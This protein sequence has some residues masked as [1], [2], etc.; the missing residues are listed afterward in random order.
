VSGAGGP[1][2]RDRRALRDALIGNPRLPLLFAFGVLY[3]LVDHALALGQSNAWDL[4][5]YHLYM[6]WAWVEGRLE[7]DIAAAQIQ[8]FYNPVMH[9]PLLWSAELF[10]P[11]LHTGLLAL[12]QG[13]NLFLLYG[14][15]LQVLS[16]PYPRGARWGAL[17]VAVMGATGATVLSELGTG[18]GENLVSLPLL[19]GALVLLR[20]AKAARAAGDA[21]PFPFAAIVAAGLLVGAATG[22][23]L[24]MAPFAASL[25][26]C[27]ALLV[28]SRRARVRLVLGLACG[29]ALGFVLAAGPWMFELWSR[30]GNPLYPGFSD[31]FPTLDYPAVDLRE[32]YRPPRTLIEWVAYPLVWTDH[33]ARAS[34]VKFRDHRILFWYLALLLLPWW[35][36]RGVARAHDQRAGVFLS[37]WLASSYVVSLALFGYYRFLAPLEMLAPAATAWLVAWVWPSGGWRWYVLSG[38]FLVTAATQRTPDRGYVPF[39]QSYVRL[40]A[41]ALPEQAHVVLAGG[42]PTAF[43]ALALGPGHDYIRAGGNLAGSLRAPW[44]IDN[45]VAARLDG[46]DRP[47]VIVVQEDLAGVRDDLARFGLETNP[48]DC[49]VVRTNLLD[50]Y[51]WPLS[52]CP[53]HRVRP[54]LTALADARTA[55]AAKCAAA[56]GDDAGTRRQC[57]ALA[58]S[59]PAFRSL[60]EA[61]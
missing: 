11:R 22:L 49:V 38:L 16:A 44:A 56:D 12:M 10:G 45:R 42:A 55:W 54:A 24:A 20:A 36:T 48:S 32:A 17:F 47:I 13:A 35:R 57:K 6:P 9:V 58:A 14:I 21:A 61:P 1:A 51:Q 31:W 7:Q 40:E 33:A 39:E 41:P 3:L 50:D 18:Y 43:V 46:D 34:E 26:A 25:V 28:E 15:A 23:K 37:M 27:A 5:N 4:R 53:G 8:T 52:F 30:Y 60:V 19:G 29:S 2:A 59:E